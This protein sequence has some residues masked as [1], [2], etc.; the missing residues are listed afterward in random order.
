MNIIIG[1]TLNQIGI[2]LKFVSLSTYNF[3]GDF[4]ANDSQM[5]LLNFLGTVLDIIIGGHSNVAVFRDFRL[6]HLIVFSD[7]DFRID[8]TIN[9][10]R[11]SHSHLH[12]W[13]M[14]QLTT[15][16]QSNIYRIFNVNKVLVQA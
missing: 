15:S 5:D 9:K 1:H 12:S 4:A 11:R 14:V 8:S 3:S 6:F 2:N 16:Y 13:F 7:N 10:K